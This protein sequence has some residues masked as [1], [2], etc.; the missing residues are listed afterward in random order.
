MD[1]IK[2]EF[3]RE[4]KGFISFTTYVLM[5]KLLCSKREGVATNVYVKCYRYSLKKAFFNI[6]RRRER[7]EIDRSPSA[8]IDGEYVNIIFHNLFMSLFSQLI[9]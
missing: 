4:L 8:S 7:Q 5:T 3:F 9:E 6:W 1:E 2:F